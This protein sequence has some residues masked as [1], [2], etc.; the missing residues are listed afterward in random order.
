MSR[1]DRFCA[2][3]EG[4]VTFQVV[5]FEGS[6]DILFNY[7][8]T[9]VGGECPDLDG[10]ASATVGIQVGPDVATQYGFNTPVLADGTSLLWTVG[11]GDPPPQ[12]VIAVTPASADFGTV[13]VGSQADATFV[14]KNN[15]TGTLTGQAA[16]A[17]PFGIV[18]GGTYSLA[19]GQTQVVTARFAPTTAGTF[20]GDITFTGGGGALRPVSGVGTAAAPCVKVPG[21]QLKLGRLN[22]PG[23]NTLSLK[24]S[25]SL[26]PAE[27][28][29][30]DPSASG[31]RIVLTDGG[32]G[33]VDV[34]VPAGPWDPVARKGWKLSATGNNYTF[35]DGSGFGITKVTVKKSPS[36]PGL[37]KV[38]ATG[39]NASFE[40]ASPPAVEVTLG[41]AC[42]RATFPGPTPPV[43]LYNGTGTTLLCR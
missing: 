3:F 13:G 41:G 38:Q 39:K 34:V 9:T 23:A 40:V 12:P 15:G 20:P 30:L 14:V 32:S 33:L 4:Y 29:A 10:G 19:A 8:D 42:F 17:A 26:T 24:G 18:S 43:C 6:S 37:V 7:P 27:S 2:L 35:V 1:T 31:V 36:I 21:F 11:Q 22:A 28:A 16:T 25:L 5:F